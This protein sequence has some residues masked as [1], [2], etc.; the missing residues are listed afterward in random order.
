[1]PTP[2][3]VRPGAAKI[4]LPSGPEVDPVNQLDADEHR[5]STERSAL[6]ERLDLSPPGEIDETTRSLLARV[7][8]GGLAQPT[9]L[10]DTDGY[11]L[12]C[13]DGLLEASG[14]DR[15]SL[16]GVRAWEAP[17]WRAESG[18]G[19]TMRFLYEQA[20]DGQVVRAL[21]DLQRHDEHLARTHEIS[22]QPLH[23]D[24]GSLVFLLAE[25]VDVGE[26]LAAERVIDHQTRALDAMNLRYADLVAASPDLLGVHDLAG[27]YLRANP[28]SQ[29]ILG[30]SPEELIGASPADLVH[31]DDRIMTSRA[32]HPAA[33]TYVD[34]AELTV[35]L[36][37][38]DGSYINCHLQLA[39]KHGPGGEVLELQSRLRDLSPNTDGDDVVRRA[40]HDELT[41]LPN[42]GLLLDRLGQALA[43]A[44]RSQQPVAVLMIDLD[45]FAMVNE[46]IGRQS[47]DAA[48]RALAER[49][50]G[51]VRPGDSV[52]RVGG[53]EFIMVCSN[54][55]GASGAAVVAR[56][57]LSAL[58]DPVLV[59]GRPVFLS[60]SVG[61]A[62]SG[63]EHEPLELIE[64]ADIA[65]DRAKATGRGQFSVHD[66][67]LDDR[68]R[69]AD[70][71]DFALRRALERD[72]FRLHYQPEHDLNTGQL[73]GF[74]ALVR[75]ERVE[76]ELVPPD[77]FIPAAEASGMIVPIG[78]WVINEACRQIRIWTALNG[79]PP[80]PV[81]VNLSA[82]QL[83]EP[84]LVSQISDALA[85]NG[86]SP[87]SL[88][89]ELTESAMLE[90]KSTAVEQL[91]QLRELGLRIGLD[92]FGTGF[93]SLTHLT[94]FPLDVVKI[95]RS[96]VD[97][98]GRHGQSETIV[99][100][101]IS[102]AH[103]LGLVVIA[104][105][106]ETS[107]QLTELRRLECDQAVGYYFSRPLEPA[108]AG[109][110]LSG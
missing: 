64:S 84:D 90:D 27:R 86:L 52:A 99:A 81:W 61:I 94:E 73:V 103:G 98:L 71:L 57:I 17:W 48:L 40:L 44:R 107:M 29:A 3:S 14:V 38:A 35:R 2:F 32:F 43:N 13:S 68:I 100:A 45:G 49:L 6:R 87:E 19:E 5:R 36:R 104:E 85:A 11:V 77:E 65:M 93:S 72:E 15:S 106:V 75:W 92:D 59:N 102:M 67:D 18:S 30:L 108:R 24:D 70:A 60:A 74:E 42:Q 26:R 110:L 31:P 58:D 37:H 105:G 88:C 10:V 82:R 96:F 25:A 46:T 21:V 89:L 39:P 8:L 41:G 66:P 54:T 23:D 50:A 109:T 53:D 69:D 79:S 78:A 51:L 62:T 76:G 12:D 56:R 33:R 83:S 28:A 55:D 9:F 34:G 1:M 20:S 97:G 7:V 95:D 4:N 91:T 80:P 63:G 22:L 101:V 47:G 16:K